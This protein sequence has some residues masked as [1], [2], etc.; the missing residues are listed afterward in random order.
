M[1]KAELIKNCQELSIEVNDDMTIKVLNSLLNQHAEA[2]YEQYMSTS[3]NDEVASDSS[4][5][6]THAIFNDERTKE[7]SAL[8][9]ATRQAKALARSQRENKVNNVLVTATI[10]RRDAITKTAIIETALSVAAQTVTA[11]TC[12]QVEQFIQ[13]D[14]TREDSFYKHESSIVSRVRNHIRHAMKK[15]VSVDAND[16]ITFHESFLKIVR[17]ENHMKRVRAII[18][19]VVEKA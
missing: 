19:E 14:M 5:A 16:D 7:V 12:Q 17:D 8:N 18:A 9:A 10:R 4:T 1:R 15:L 3:D 13:E 11:C 2:Q 6:T